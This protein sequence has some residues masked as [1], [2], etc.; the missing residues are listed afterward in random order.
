[1][2]FFFYNGENGS[3]GVIFCLDSKTIHTLT[4]CPIKSIVGQAISECVYGGGGGGGGGGAGSSNN[5]KSLLKQDT[6]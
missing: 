1:M 4:D 2:R 5:N 6:P 3:T